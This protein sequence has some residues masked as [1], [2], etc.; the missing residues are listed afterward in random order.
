MFQLYAS[1]VRGRCVGDGVPLGMFMIRAL[2]SVMAPEMLTTPFRT[3]RSCHSTATRAMFW[4]RM[5]ERR[6]FGIQK[7]RRNIRTPF[8]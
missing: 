1:T 7:C 4:F 3:G 6:V 2:A 5:F 8:V